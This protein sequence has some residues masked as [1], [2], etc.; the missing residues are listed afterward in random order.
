MTARST[1]NMAGQTISRPFD[2]HIGL[3]KCFKSCTIIST[4]GEVMSKIK[5]AVIFMEHG[6][7]T[8]HV[9]YSSVNCP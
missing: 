2:Q 1:A 5:M 6:V 9:A 8:I 3:Y 7:M 4:D